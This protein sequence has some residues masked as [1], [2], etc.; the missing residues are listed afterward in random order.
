MFTRFCHWL[1][2]C[3][4]VFA[5]APRAWAVPGEAAAVLRECGP[6]SA[7]QQVISPVTSQLERDLTYSN[8]DLILHFQPINGAWSFTT[9]WW[10]HLPATRNEVE[11]QFPCFRKAMEDAA[12]APEPAIDPTLSAQSS[13]QEIDPRS[14]GIQHLWLI[15]VLVISL[16]AVA[17][18]PSRRMRGSAG[19]VQRGFRKPDLSN[20]R[21][22]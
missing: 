15:V 19:P 22:R 12:N 18:W 20:P 11:K 10:G 5:L 17:F 3:L 2:A 16:L 21:K 4:L 7:D 8:N 14:F 6:P 1:P 9:A 13:A